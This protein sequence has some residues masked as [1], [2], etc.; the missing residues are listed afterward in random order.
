[1]RKAQDD[2]KLLATV[3]IVAMHALGLHCGNGLRSATVDMLWRYTSESTQ[4][5]DADCDITLLNSQKSDAD[6]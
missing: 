3:M 1:M 4:S 2:P 5:A 6:A